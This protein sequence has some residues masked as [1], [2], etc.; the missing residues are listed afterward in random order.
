M[1]PKARHGRCDEATS[2]VSTSR[3]PAI[4][5]TAA[6]LALVS[7][8]LAIATPAI[9]QISPEEHAKHHPG[10]G[11]G[12]PGQAGQPG[13]GGMIGE[14][15]R[16]MEQMHAPPAKEVYPKLMSLP[17]LTPAARDEI[18]KN[19]HEQMKEGAA[20]LSQGLDRLTQA[21]PPMITRRCSRRRPRCVR[22]LR[23]LRAALPATVR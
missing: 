14:M 7:S 21:T 12:Q 3:R 10:Q 6:R 9:A 8:L 23:G 15:G 11:Q 16:M 13:P 17:E 4:L 1:N 18:E 5:R 2:D 19:S 22:A 20:L